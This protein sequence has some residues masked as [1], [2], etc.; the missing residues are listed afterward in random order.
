MKKF[1][2]DTITVEAIGIETTKEGFL[3]I[4]AR[5]TRAGV[6][7]YSC[8]K[9]YRSVEE[10]SRYESVK[11][12]VGKSVT[13]LHPPKDQNGEDI[14][15]NPENWKK[16]E[17]GHVLNPAYNYDSNIISSDIIIKDKET[18]DRI[19]TAKES[20]ESIE[21]SC[22]YWS[23]LTKYSQPVI[24]ADQEV[25]YEQTDIIYNHV[26]LVPKGRA[27]SSIKLMLDSMDNKP[28]V[29]M[30][31]KFKEKTANGKKIIDA[32]EVEVAENQEAVINGY[33]KALDSAC[34][35]IESLSA[36]LEASEKKVNDAQTELAELKKTTIDAKEIENLV[37][38]KIELQ[39]ICDGLGLEL[40]EKS[41]DAMENAIVK[42]VMPKVVLEGKSN[43][44]RSAIVDSSLDLAREAVKNNDSV[45]KGVKIGDKT[46]KEKGF[47]E[48]LEK[49][50]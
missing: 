38:R 4:P 26:A 1:F 9:V 22:G 21:I 11:S 31:L 48:N 23:V 45:K 46:E 27:G 24:M 28:E 30:K 12:L 5:L 49:G 7:D 44:Y 3:R 47:F 20:G 40:A 25:E 32:V 6:F 33:D 42:E 43:D 8:G 37:N 16:Y 34:A 50:E 15:V 39:T 41:I 29:R 35:E 2:H 13:D 36:K 10:V 17:V 19:L 14:F 18:I